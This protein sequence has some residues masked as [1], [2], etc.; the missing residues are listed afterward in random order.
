VTTETRRPRVTCVYHLRS[1][2]LY[3]RQGSC[4]CGGIDIEETWDG[5]G[6]PEAARAEAAAHVGRKL[7]G[8][9]GLVLAWLAEDCEGR[10]RLNFLTDLE[11]WD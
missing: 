4:T 8:V 3:E 11:D 10:T 2:E 7:D 9:G 1:C 5:S 6:D